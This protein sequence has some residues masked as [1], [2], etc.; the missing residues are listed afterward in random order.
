MQVAFLLNH[1]ALH[2]AII[3]DAHCKHDV[4]LLV[5]SRRVRIGTFEDW[6][7]SIL[8]RFGMVRAHPASALLTGDLCHMLFPTSKLLFSSGTM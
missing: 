3:N 7:T 4:F 6:L 8:A 5:A 1:Q 2:A